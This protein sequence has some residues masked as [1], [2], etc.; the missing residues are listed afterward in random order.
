MIAPLLA[1]KP[2]GIDF[3]Y[4]SHDVEELLVKFKTA[5]PYLLPQTVEKVK[6]ELDQTKEEL[7][8][9]EKKY[10]DLEDTF[11]EKL[12]EKQKETMKA[13]L[14]MLK[15]QGIKAEWEEEQNKEP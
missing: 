1:H 9:S 8:E 5:L 2:K 15:S 13:V 6:S 12:A 10:E 7:T 4:S 3:H 11:V 14:K